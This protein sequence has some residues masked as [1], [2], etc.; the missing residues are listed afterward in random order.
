[1]SRTG[2]IKDGIVERGTLVEW[3]GSGWGW[4]WVMGVSGTIQVVAL[5]VDVILE[6]ALAGFEHSCR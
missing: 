5:W 1:V 4:D 2:V 6:A 3:S